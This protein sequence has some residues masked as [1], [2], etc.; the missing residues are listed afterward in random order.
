MQLGMLLHS[1]YAPESRVYVQQIVGDF[2]EPVDA[3][4]FERAWLAVVEQQPLLRTWFSLREDPPVQLVKRHIV[5][6]IESYDWFAAKAWLFL[7]VQA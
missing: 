3:E 2:H 4:L 1:L 6:P 5:V 7:R